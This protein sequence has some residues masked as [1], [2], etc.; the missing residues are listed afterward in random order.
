MAAA[1]QALP[2]SMDAL[3][4]FGTSGIID[5]VAPKSIMK[6]TMRCILLA[7]CFLAI[8]NANAQQTTN[9]PERVEWYENLAF[10]MFI[11]WNVDVALGGV[12]SHSLA[13]AS[14]DYAKRYFTELPSYFNPSRFDPTAWAK[15]AKLTGMKYVVFT[16]KHHS[17]FC[18]FSTKTTPFNVIN[19]PY[20]KDV[21]KQIVEAFRK[22]GIAIGFYFSPEDFYF[23]HQH[24][25]PMGRLQVPEQFPV[26]NPQ[27][28]DYDKRQL[29]EL[30][31]NYGKIDILFIDGPG[32]GLREYA[33]SLNPDLVITRDVMNTPEQNT[34]DAPLPR[35]WEAC[36]TTGTEWSYKALN[37]DIFKSGTEVIDKL[38]DIRSKGGNFL[39]NVGPT[40]EGIIQDKEANVLTEIGLWMFANSESIYQVKPLP[41]IREGRY[42]FT[43]SNDGKS[44][45]AYII[46][47]DPSDWAYGTRSTFTFSH[48]SG[49]GSTKAGVLG[50]G[51]QLVEYRKDFDAGVY[52]MPSPVGLTVSAVNGQR[53]YTDNQ[54]PNAVVLKIEGARFQDIRVR[55]K[56]SKMDG[57]K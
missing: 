16:T 47:K 57:A 1:D 51:S 22:E 45:Y 43:Q 25:I 17:G 20:G 30:L 41:V 55:E 14:D 35:P 50:Y 23:F 54:W 33:W 12:I 9:R 4:N 39:L 48:L 37:D 3:I 56:Q 36:Y 13:G 6:T 21:T 40:S 24:N 34:P 42:Y 26:N 49:S 32:D 38:I 29:H 44:I 11:H 27:L 18:M 8:L 28:M 53:F 7:G 10:G 19:T 5:Y 2:V 31:T 52:T 46:R 15:K